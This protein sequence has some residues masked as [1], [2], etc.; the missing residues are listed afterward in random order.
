MYIIYRDNLGA[1]RVELEPGCVVS[2][3]DGKAYFSAWETLQDKYCF[4]HDMVVDANNIVEI[5]MEEQ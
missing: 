3:C 4:Y 5:G 2:F 1:V